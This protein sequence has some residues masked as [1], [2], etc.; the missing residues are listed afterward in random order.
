VRASHSTEAAAPLAASAPVRAK[1]RKSSAPKAPAIQRSMA[2]R[3]CRY[4]EKWSTPSL[5]MAIFGSG[6]VSTNEVKVSTEQN[7]SSVPM[8]RS[9]GFP[10]ESAALFIMLR[11][12]KRYSAQA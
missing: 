1:E 8:I 10:S 7:W 11:P 5:T 12:L 4:M 3:K 6:S 2:T 9:F